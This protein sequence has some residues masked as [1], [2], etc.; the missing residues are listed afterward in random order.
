MCGLVDHDDT[1]LEQLLNDEK[2]SADTIF[3]DLARETAAGQIVSILFGSALN[4]VGIRRLLKMLRHDTPIAAL[5]ANRLAIDGA[6]AQVFKVAHG[7]AVG[8]LAFARVFGAPRWIKS[9]TM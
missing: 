1:L 2:P 5:T 8:R 7:S 4:G 9:I 3:G 6:A